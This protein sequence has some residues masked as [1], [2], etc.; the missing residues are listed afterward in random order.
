MIKPA[1]VLFIMRNWKLIVHMLL[2]T[3]RFGVNN[4][5]HSNFDSILSSYR[6]NLVENYKAAKFRATACGF[7][8]RKECANLGWRSKI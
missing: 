8:T 7:L 5:W 2:H 6:G 4:Q 1:G 3:K